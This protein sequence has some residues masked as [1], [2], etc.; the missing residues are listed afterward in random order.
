MDP[1]LAHPY[2]SSGYLMIETV[3][4]T[5][6]RSFREAKLRDCRRVNVIVGENASGKTALLEGMFLAAGPSPEI[7]LRIKGFRGME[8]LSFE[9]QESQ[10]NEILWR[11]LF[12]QFNTRKAA[13]VSLSGKET[14]S[15]RSITVTYREKD[16]LVIPQQIERQRKN[17]APKVIE[18]REFSPITFR[19][20]WPHG[21]FTNVE[22]RFIDG[23]VALPNTLPDS[24]VES[25]FFA[26]NRTYSIKETANRFSALSRSYRE[27]N[28][29]KLFSEHFPQV[30]NISLVDGI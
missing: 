28:A 4:L 22:P 13:Y 23:K 1:S 8:N 12:F 11:D 18:Q 3:E 29:I 24:N 27:T 2:Q 19:W 16:Q 21:R 14:S 7:A 25:S 10:M 9:G 5:N 26:A 20:R 17:K 30:K 6:F 15:T